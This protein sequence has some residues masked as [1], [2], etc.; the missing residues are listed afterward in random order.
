MNKKDRGKEA[1][2]T[3]RPLAYGEEYVRSSID[4]MEELGRAL[5]N[6]EIDINELE[7]QMAWKEEKKV[8]NL[9]GVTSTRKKLKP[10][11]ISKE[12]LE[13]AGGARHKLRQQKE[14]DEDVALLEE[15]DNE[16]NENEELEE[17]NEELEEDNE[18]VEEDNEEVEEN[19]EEVEENEEEV[20]ENEE[21]VEENE[22]EVEESEE[23]EV[24]SDDD[25][26]STPAEAE[27]ARQR[28][29][30]LAREFMSNHIVPPK[31]Y[32]MI[33]GEENSEEDSSEEE[34]N[35]EVANDIVGMCIID[36]R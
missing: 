32:K 23:L 11:K 1:V 30:A 12:A 3:K 24:E 35:A 6:G 36:H 4:G 26:E 20:E 2:K 17:E 28:R 22:E 7:T 25:D 34:D 27:A 8:K 21:E 14:K 31:V 10:V 33:S 29:I 9:E 13:F 19:E 15:E 18:E 16:L 5:E